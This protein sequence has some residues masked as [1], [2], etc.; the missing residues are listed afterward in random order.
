MRCSVFALGLALLAGGAQ[1]QELMSLDEM[2]AVRGGIL[3]PWGQE[4]GFGAV[5]RTYVDGDLAL[6]SQLTWTKDGPVQTYE[7]GAPTQNLAAAAA[8]F[9]L[10]IDADAQGVLSPGE[11]GATV[12][13]HNLT[14]G[15]IAGLILNNA[16]NR[17]IRQS[18]EVSLNIPN[19]AA[20]QKDLAGQAI[21]AQLQS[22][23]G[24]ALRDSITR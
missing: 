15:R 6:Q 7:A 3:T 14:D 21:N 1:A 9:G 22:A 10:Q 5:V 11:N 20:M 8:A 4:I 18:T 24:Q 12:V 13:L 2:D 19:L 23:L 16:D 17:D